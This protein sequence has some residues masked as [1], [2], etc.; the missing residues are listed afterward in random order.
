MTIEPNNWASWS[1]TGHRRQPGTLS[2][3]QIRQTVHQENVRCLGKFWCQEPGWQALVWPGGSIGT[4]M[5]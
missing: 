4:D 3:H 2:N 5:R 1:S